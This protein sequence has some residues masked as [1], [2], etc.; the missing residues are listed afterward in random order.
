[1]NFNELLT[2]IAEDGE[3]VTTQFERLLG[4]DSMPEFISFNYL[5]KAGEH[6]KYTVN[7]GMEYQRIKENNIN[8]IQK[9][10]T[11]A[12]AVKQAIQP[13][14]EKIAGS[15]EGDVNG[16]PVQ[17]ILAAVPE[18]LEKILQQESKSLNRIEQDKPTA[19]ASSNQ[20]MIKGIKKNVETG[21]YYIEGVVRSKKLLGAKAEYGSV[22]SKT[23]VTA[24]EPFVKKYLKLSKPQKFIIHP[25]L[26][27]GIKVRQTAV[28]VDDQETQQNTVE[29]TG[30]FRADLG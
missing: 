9:A 18:I 8:K 25:S 1:M 20:Q 22:N 15:P 27:E 11:D 4:G 10:Q 2:F 5:T 17:S 13:K 26:M 28:D 7:I 21:V 14:L 6:A 23:A 12:D 3:S 29:L 19:Q 24:G 16:H 30:E